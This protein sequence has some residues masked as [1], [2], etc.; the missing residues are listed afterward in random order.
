[1]LRMKVGEPITVIRRLLRFADHPVVVEEIY[2]PGEA[3]AQLSLDMLNEYQG[4]FYGL[5]ESR[6]ATRMIRAE[7]RLRAV[8]C[9][10]AQAMLLGVPEGSPLLSVERVSYTYGDRPV[11]WRRGLYS[12]ADHYYLNE[13]T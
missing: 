9:E 1:M 6:F 11:E 8:A 4:S 10:K 5:L 2:L 12:T 7:E 13:L 3:F